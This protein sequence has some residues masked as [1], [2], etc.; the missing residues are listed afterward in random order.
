V[1]INTAVIKT[2]K[3]I[4]ETASRFGSQSLVVSIDAKKDWLGRWRVYTHSGCHK[5]NIE[6]VRWAVEA[7]R[8]GAGEILINCINSDGSM[9]GYNLELINSVAMAVGIPVI[10]AGGAGEIEH[11]V[12]AKS[13]GANAMAAGSMFVY[14]GKLR[15]ILINYP[16]RQEIE[17]AFNP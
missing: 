9:A 7:E 16:N 6:P 3:L 2:P 15:G 13:A 5:T 1:A 14:T 11:L 12:A 8:L 4:S 10:A 17:A